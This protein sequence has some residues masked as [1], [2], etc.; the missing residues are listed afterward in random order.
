MRN[1]TILKKMIRNNSIRLPQELKARKDLECLSEYKNLG[2]GMNKDLTDER[3]QL[4][5]EGVRIYPGNSGGFFYDLDMLYK[6]NC[7]NI[8][9]EL[10]NIN[11][12]YENAYVS[13]GVDD[14]ILIAF[15]GGLTET[16]SSVSEIFFIL[17]HEIGH[18][19]LKHYNNAVRHAANISNLEHTKP[20]EVLQEF[21]QNTS[22]N[23]N[24]R[25][26]MIKCCQLE[27]L[28]A[29]RFGLLFQQDYQASITS[30][31]YLASGRAGNIFKLGQNA[32]LEQGREL[33][34]TPG[35]PFEPS[36]IHPD[37]PLRAIALKEFYDSDACDHFNKDT[38]KTPQSLKRANEK[39]YNW[40][41]PED[42]NT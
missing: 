13:L 39:I 40:L 24:P 25:D 3:K 5:R 37:M 7:L 16:L 6:I 2:N 23:S 10:Y 31:M 27:E 19:V 36:K 9:I 38:V 21:S 26:I 29:D 4:M 18:Y 35:Y 17:G 42:Q 22:T 33:V 28:S 8:N 14:N 15:Q 20:E 1:Y 12:S 32:F 11:A 41:F 34:T 30:L